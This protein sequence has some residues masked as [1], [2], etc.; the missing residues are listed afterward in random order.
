MG[1]NYW[2]KFV[3]YAQLIS[4]AHILQDCSWHC[5]IILVVP[6]VCFVQDVFISTLS[7]YIFTYEETVI[8]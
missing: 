7:R 4:V 5:S 6:Y 2:M 1:E 3:N 8:I